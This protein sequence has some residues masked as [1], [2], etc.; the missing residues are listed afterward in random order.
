MNHII[1]YDYKTIETVLY[2]NL[3]SM[4]KQITSFMLY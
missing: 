1:Y 4:T 2:K 3:L